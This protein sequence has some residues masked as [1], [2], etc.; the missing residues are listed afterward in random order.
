MATRTAKLRV[1]LDGE[2]Q[3][4]AAIA[5]IN[6]ESK[7]LGAEM[8]KLSAE[9]KGNESSVEA[10]TK[11]QTL[12]DRA[13]LESKAKVEETRK[14]L[15]S[16]K[17][18]L[19]RVRE[20][21]GA[22]SEEYKQ[23]QKKVQEYE[24]AL[25]NAETQEL[26]LE[27]A[28]RENNDALEDSE[29]ALDK[30]GD[31]A[32]ETGGKTKTLGDYVSDLAG[33]FGIKLPD[34]LKKSLDGMKTFSAGTV[35]AVGAV[36]AAVA[37]AVKGYKQ[38]FELTTEQAKA[39]DELL[40]RSMRTGL[41]TTLLQQLDYSSAFLD[42]DGIDQSLNKLILSMDKAREGAGA[43]AEAFAE[44]GVSVKNADGSLRD[45][46]EVF[47]ETIDALGNM[48]DQE[49]A[50]IIANELFG[51]SYQDLKPLIA[52]GSQELQH[53]ADEAVETGYVLEESGV[54]ILAEVDDA[55]EK[56]RLQW[57][58]LK[59]QLALQFAPVAKDTFETFGDLMKKAG[60]ALVESRLI[61][62]AGLFLQGLLNVADAGSSLASM[63][64]S[65]LNPIQQVSNALRGL[66]AVLAMI[67]DYMDA[68]NSLMH[69]DF[70]G[71]KTAL[72]W[73]ASS[74]QLSH[75]QQVRY[76]N[77]WTYS[78]GSWTTR[79]SYSNAAGYD[80]SKGLWYDQHG[81]YIYGYNAS[82]N[83]NWRGGLTWVGEAGP[84]LVS[85]PRGSQIYSAQDSRNMG[86]GQVININVNGIQQLDEIVSWYE[87]RRVRGRMA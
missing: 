85:L 56:N 37:A 47:L 14:Q 75:L 35:A 31:A 87:S 1:E 24:Y 59:N 21:Q 8:K 15:D 61:E 29:K 67:S 71:V 40:T 6:R 50:A 69:M 43:Q 63:M 54:K 11:K 23:A 17:A 86:G 55:V 33:Q 73:N 32:E 51:K 39:A 78:N 13:R 28:I 44:L 30:T 25:A 2:K 64:P 79:S 36:T 22:S 27:N 66:A 74:G 83:D 48:N 68:V 7:T 3:Y 77:D 60:D 57:E 72:G 41:D 76:G 52:A 65:W 80:S 49:E 45:S 58:G 82:G 18:A 5:E 38:L 10:L 62:N 42:F 34:G 16:W 46:W 53:F 19:E 12:L 4:K 9:Y 70:N 81:N 84:E 20:E 26:E